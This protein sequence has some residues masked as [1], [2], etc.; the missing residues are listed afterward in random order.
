MKNI[1]KTILSAMLSLLLISFVA[2]EENESVSYIPQT[3]VEAILIVDEPIQD[4]KIQSSQPLGS[5]IDYAGAM[6]RDAE[7]IIFEDDNV[8]PLT[9][10]Q[11]TES[12]A[13]YYFDGD[14]TVKPNTIYRI[15]IKLKD[16]TLIDGE[17]L[18][19]DRTAWVSE[20]IDYIQYPKDTINLP[21]TDNIE[22]KRVD[23]VD[24]YLLGVK[25][26]DIKE[27][28]IYLDEVADSELNRKIDGAKNAKEEEDDEWKYKETS[29]W[30][31][32]PNTKTPVVWRIFKWFGLHEATLFA[33]DTNFRTWFLQSVMSA[34]YEPMLSRINGGHGVFGS[35]S[36]VRD[37]F[38]LLKNQ[39]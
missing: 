12:E 27:Y 9:I 2:C 6:I 10:S 1:N 24:Y 13:G 5:D 29:Q 4:I 39:P 33:P 37:T 15:E 26:L 7:V 18:T 21:S 19:P 30:A 36:A 14:Y 28:G 38:I 34:Q 22:W 16:G 31:F 11:D 32:I 8:Y 20:Q 23:S 25:C 35:A 3:F 17:T